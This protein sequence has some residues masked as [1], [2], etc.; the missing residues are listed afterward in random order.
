MVPKKIPNNKTRNETHVLHVLPFETTSCF[1]LF[2]KH[3]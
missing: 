1:Q 2:V 3:V